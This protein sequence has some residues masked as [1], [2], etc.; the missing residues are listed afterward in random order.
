RDDQVV[1]ADA[2]V[3]EPPRAG[4]LREAEIVGGEEVRIAVAEPVGCTL[5]EERLQRLE[6][7]TPEAG[8]FD[9]AVRDAE[10]AVSRRRASEVAGAGRRSRDG[11][12]QGELAGRPRSLARGQLLEVEVVAVETGGEPGV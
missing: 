10:A 1:G 7:G 6:H 11:A 8:A 9:A 2:A 12:L 3:R 4:E 5:T